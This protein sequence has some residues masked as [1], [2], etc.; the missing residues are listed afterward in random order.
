MIRNPQYD[1]QF[2]RTAGFTGVA[3]C[4]PGIRDAKVF[5]DLWLVRR[6]MTG[7]PQI[8]RQRHLASSSRPRPTA[9]QIEKLV[10][11]QASLASTFVDSFGCHELLVKVS[12]KAFCTREQSDE[13]FVLGFNRKSSNHAS[14]V[15]MAGVAP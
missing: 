3:S 11:Q 9:R 6:G 10:K 4:L 1:K 12:M 5:L 8:A 2:A 7:L 15:A 14:Q 13:L